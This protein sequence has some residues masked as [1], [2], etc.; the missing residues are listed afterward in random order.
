[1][2]IPSARCRRARAGCST[3]PMR[4]CCSMWRG[5]RSRHPGARKETLAAL[6]ACAP[7]AAALIVEPLMLGAGGMLTYPAQMLAE[8]REICARHGTL[9]IADEVMTGFG[10]HRHALRL[11]AGRRHRPTYCAWPRGFRAAACRWPPPCATPQ[12]FQAHYSTDRSATFFHSV[13]QFFHRQSHRLRR[14]LRQSPGLE[15]RAGAGAHRG[16]E[17]DAGRAGWR[18]C[19]AIRAFPTRAAA[20]PSRRWT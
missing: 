18:G 15:R 12:I 4:R 11:R 16:S 9:F 3:P 14:R 5:C 7:D 10:P 2:A 8:M 20:A 19:A 6:E 1:M 13:T 17:P